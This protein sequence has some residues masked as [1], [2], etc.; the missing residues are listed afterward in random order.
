MS[1]SPVRRPVAS[2]LPM[3]QLA[4][5]VMSALRTCGLSITEYSL[6]VACQR[7]NSMKV[8]LRQSDCNAQEILTLRKMSATRCLVEYSVETG[9]WELRSTGKLLVDMVSFL[10]GG[11]AWEQKATAKILQMPIPLDTEQN[12]KETVKS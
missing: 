2:V 10:A 5:H 4:N 3:P 12:S 8:A 9:K 1:T 11:P 6:L 7:D